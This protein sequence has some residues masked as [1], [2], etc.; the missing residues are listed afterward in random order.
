MFPFQNKSEQNAHITSGLTSI[1]E[2]CMEMK[3]ENQN[4]LKEL[5]GKLR[6]AER[7]DV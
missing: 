5:E 7:R 2:K 4:N 6:S 3:E 1:L